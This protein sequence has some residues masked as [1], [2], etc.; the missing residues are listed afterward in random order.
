MVIKRSNKHIEALNPP[1]IANINPM[2]IYNR[3]K[4]FQTFVE[5]EDIDIVFMSETWERED[6]T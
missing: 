3:I 6:K 4:E 5:Q 2:S 1:V